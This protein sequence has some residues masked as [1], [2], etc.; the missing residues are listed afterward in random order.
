MM[1]DPQASRQAGIQSAAGRGKWFFPLVLAAVAGALYWQ[2]IFYDWANYDDIWLII[3]NPFVR[4]LGLE[5]LNKMFTFFSLRSYYPIR[6]LSL[7]VDY[8]FWGLNPM[9]FHL[10]NLLFHLA[11]IWLLYGLAA[12][13]GAA[14]GLDKNRAR[15]LAFMAAAFFGLHPA[16]VDVVAS[17]AGREELLMLFFFLICLH[18]QMLARASSNK[19]LLRV[20]IAYACAFSC[21]SNIMGIMIPFVVTLYLLLVERE[22]KLSVL[23]A[24][25]W[26]L[27]AIALAAF[28]LKMLSLGIW[29]QEVKEITFPHVPTALRNTGEIFSHVRLGEGLTLAL[30]DRIRTVI[31]LFGQN[32]MH[33]FHPA[34]MPVIYPNTYPPSFWDTKILWGLFCMGAAVLALWLARRKPVVLFCLGW[35]LLGLLPSAQI[36]PHHIFRADRFLYLPMAGLSIACAW[37]VC[38][39]DWR[40]RKKKAQALFLCFVFLLSVRSSLH[41]N[42]WSDALRLHQY[43][44]ETSPDNYM[45]YQYL[46]GEYVREWMYDEAKKTYLQALKVEPDQEPL[47]V[48]LLECLVKAGRP[49]EAE[50]QAERAIRLYPRNANFHNNLGLILAKNGK[51]DQAIAEM[52]K[53]LALDPENE[54]FYVN[55]GTLLIKAG[56]RD[57]GMEHYRQALGVNPRNALAHHFLGME[58]EKM[59]YPNNALAHY[60]AA[61]RYRPGYLPAH[62]SLRRLLGK[63]LSRPGLPKVGGLELEVLDEEMAPPYETGYGNKPFFPDKL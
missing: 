22:K 41:L 46:G 58:L 30:P 57:D 17:L 8:A 5:N 52:E 26:F 47:W 36:M 59:G 7:A 10:S 6:V 12:R 27:W 54:N 19:L 43:C 42:V 34:V 11:N 1:P 2:S 38:G 3:K 49:A 21:A 24:C 48:L 63:E 20:L 35:F 18:L 37:A 62:V 15:V 9:G 61:V 33:I 45:V 4:S 29:D 53:A 51:R 28:F 44:V 40:R 25:T 16:M 50:A 39:D 13:L 23:A 32:V 56:R 14:G 55:L 60:R 31:S